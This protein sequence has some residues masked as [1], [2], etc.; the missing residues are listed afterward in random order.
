V[1]ESVKRRESAWSR[2]G[3]A[4]R[5]VLWFEPGEIAE[6][7]AKLRAKKK[8]RYETNWETT[9]LFCLIGGVFFAFTLVHWY[10]LIWLWGTKL[11]IQALNK[12]RFFD[13]MP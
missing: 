3:S 12:K 4:L 10:G 13:P 6:I 11:A 8:T 7:W 2:I 9:V 1:A 5:S